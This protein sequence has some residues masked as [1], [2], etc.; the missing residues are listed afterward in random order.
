MKEETF[1][2]VCAE[3]NRDIILR[4]AQDNKETPFGFVIGYIRDNHNIPKVDAWDMAD[5][6]LKYFELN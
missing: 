6:V 3:L 2:L 1:T 5:S 4:K